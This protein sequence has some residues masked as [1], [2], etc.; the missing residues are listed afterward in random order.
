MRVVITVLLVIVIV[1]AQVAAS[2]FA[3]TGLDPRSLPTPP[4]CV[5]GYAIHLPW[6]WVQWTHAFGQHPPL[7]LERAQF[8]AFGLP[9]AFFIPMLVLH[10]AR[11]RAARQRENEQA[12]RARELAALENEGPTR[13]W[14]RERPKAR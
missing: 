14:S 7:I 12:A 13:N 3:A 4:W 5:L 9:A 11:R 1:L 2:S 6:R 10:R 8:I